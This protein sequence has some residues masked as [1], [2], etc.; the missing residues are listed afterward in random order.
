MTVTASFKNCI[1]G[2]A[3]A[4]LSKL[5]A[6]ITTSFFRKKAVSSHTALT[7]T[8]LIRHFLILHR[9]SVR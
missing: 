1:I 2:V 5:N 7:L 3:E 4:A 8:L 6:S 9:K